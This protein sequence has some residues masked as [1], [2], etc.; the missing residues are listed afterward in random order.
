MH[1][2]QLIL[3]SHINCNT[4]ENFDYSLVVK[5]LCN[6]Q[7]VLALVDTG[8]T[9]SII[10][11]AIATCSV[12][13]ER[14]VTMK[15]AGGGEIISLLTVN[16]KF[17]IAGVTCVY[18]FKV[19]RSLGLK[20]VQMILGFDLISHYEFSIEAGRNPKIMIEG[21]SVPVVRRATPPAVNVIEE[22]SKDTVAA[23]PFEDVH[24]PHSTVV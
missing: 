6:D 23:T 15:T 24:L 14:S 1:S 18:E 19:V 13:R 16:Q 10:E 17:K 20:G 8:S 5:V 7:I 12:Q 21:I 22:G 3:I 9:V 4:T 11:H 2:L